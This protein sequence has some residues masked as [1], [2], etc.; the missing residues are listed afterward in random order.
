[1]KLSDSFR[2]LANKDYS[3]TEIKLLVSVTIYG[4]LFMALILLFGS[5][6]FMTWLSGKAAAIVN[7]VQM[8]GLELVLKGIAAWG[9]LNIVLYAI[10]GVATGYWTMRNCN[11]ACFDEP[12]T[13]VAMTNMSCFIH[14]LKHGPAHANAWM[15][16]SIYDRM[17]MTNYKKGDRESILVVAKKCDQIVSTYE[18][19]K[20]G[21]VSNT[22][23]LKLVLLGALSV[24]VWGLYPYSR[25]LKRGIINIS[26]IALRD[27]GL[28]KNLAELKPLL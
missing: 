21:I 7:G 1:M 18:D 23:T 14:A 17:V 11:K 26:K 19:M 5:K 16:N 12:D 28:V 25:A 10:I 4:Y 9:M 2:E 22:L 27:T 13:D 3:R 6:G 15:E 20:M 24:F 8:L